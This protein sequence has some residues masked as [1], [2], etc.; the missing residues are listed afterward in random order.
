MSKDPQSNDPQSN[1]PTQHDPV[2]SD[3]AL[4]E[5]F[6]ESE[7]E[8]QITHGVE[9]LQDP[10]IA[11]DDATMLPTSGDDGDTTLPEIRDDFVPGY[12]RLN[13]LGRGGMGVVY[14]ARDRRLKRTVALKMILHGSH[15]SN[16]LIERFQVE[17]EAVAQLHHPNIVQIFEVGE[18]QG[19][20]YFSLEFAEGGSLDKKIAGTPQNPREA[21]ELIE[22]LAQAMQVAHQ[23]NIIHRDLKPAN[24]LLT[25]DGKPKITDFGLAKRLDAE[26]QHTQTGAVMGTPSYMAPEQAAGRLDDIGP[27]TD[28][29]AL[30]AILYHLLTGR[31]PFLAEQQLDTMRQVLDDEPTPPR[32]LNSAIPVDLESIALKCLEKQPERRYS[33]CEEL[34]SDL[35]KFMEGEPISIRGSRW[36]GSVARSLQRGKHDFDLKAWETIL[37]WFAFFI[38]AAEVSIAVCYQLIPD[39]QEFLPFAFGT[40]I[41]QAFGFIGVL[42]WQR[43][44]WMTSIGTGARQMLSIWIAF[45]V[46]CSLTG[47]VL[48]FGS[49]Q[50]DFNYLSLH[51][52]FAILSGMI[53]FVMGGSY[54]GQCYLM[55]VLFFVLSLFM[56]LH[57]PSAPI[58]FGALWA[59]C[60]IIIGRRLRYLQSLG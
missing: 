6:P 14:R 22:T 58:A 46:S 8:T 28:I 42:I 53:F 26:S 40:R 35:R 12:D 55:G 31:P 33:T 7:G 60:L 38:F 19:S 30:G 32:R 25:E 5:T 39:Q 45:L 51:P 21:A 56:L 59:G 34:A 1:P 41:L 57:P 49:Y 37:Y 4:E 48:H 23:Q 16:E 15:A 3:D 54:W 27:A 43:N 47:I 2:V 20:P 13:E 17:A 36:M 9:P 50:D 52:H 24:I 11:H 29:Y 44:N 10:F 18:H